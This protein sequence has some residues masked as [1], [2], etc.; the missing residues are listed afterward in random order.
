MIIWTILAF[1][2]DHPYGRRMAHTNVAGLL[3]RRHTSGRSSFVRRRRRSRRRSCPRTVAAAR[4]LQARRGGAVMQQLNQQDA[5]FLYSETPRML[6]HLGS[7]H[8][9]DPT[10]AP[11]PITFDSILEHVSGRLPLARVLRRRIVRVPGNL[12]YPYWVES[13]DFDL[14]YHVRQTAL[15]PPGNLAQLWVLASRLHSYGL[16]LQRPP[17][18]LYI[19]QGVNAVEGLPSGSFGMLIKVHHSAI[20]GISGIELMNALHDLTPEGR[21]AGRG[22]LEAR[23]EART[24]RAADASRGEPHVDARPCPPARGSL[25]IGAPFRR[26]PSG[27]DRGRRAG[28]GAERQG[29]DQQGRRRVPVRVGDGEARPRRGAGRHRQRRRSHR[30]RRRPPAVPRRAGRAPERSLYAGVPISMR[31]E[32]DLGQ[33]GNKIGM[34]VVPVSTDVGRPLEAPRHDPSGDVGVEGAEHRGPGAGA[35]RQRGAVPWRAARSGDTSAASARPGRPA[36]RDRERVRH[37]RARLPGAAVPL[38][39]PDGGVLR[40]RTRL[41]PRRADPPG[42]QLRR[43]DLPRGHQLSRAGPRHGLLHRVPHRVVG[44]ARGRGRRGACPAPQGHPGESHQRRRRSEQP[45]SPRR[46]AQGG[47]DEGGAADGVEARPRAPAR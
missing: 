44:G 36:R 16:D 11:A 3:P 12:D 43:T 9:Y 19:I 8:L 30:C 14:E 10:T 31:T 1:E 4:R 18:E 7:L 23:S 47:P 20:D 6:M 5:M 34:M 46:N 27:R 41:R 39:C 2:P 45:P 29:H 38:R 17:W 42:R 26:A 24:P 13:E 32:E 35:G 22:H 33:P 28:D 37:E 40:A 15:P 21:I 25:D